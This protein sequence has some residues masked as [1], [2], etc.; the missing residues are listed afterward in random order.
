MLLFVSINVNKPSILHKNLQFMQLCLHIMHIC[1]QFMQLCLHIMH[2]CVH[3]MFMSFHIMFMS[4]DWMLPCFTL[5]PNDPLSKLWVMDDKEWVILPITNHPLPIIY[6]GGLFSI[7]FWRVEI[8]ILN[9]TISQYPNI[10]ILIN[11][12]LVFIYGCFW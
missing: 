4:I 9:I 2:I 10:I 8:N 12:V 7:P 1:V 3:I 6:W 11:T 5:K